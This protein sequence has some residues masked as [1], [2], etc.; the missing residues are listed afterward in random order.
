MDKKTIIGLVLIFAIFVGYM[1]WI[2]PSKEEQAAMRAHRDSIVAAF[3]DSVRQDSL[4]RAE[5]DSIRQ[6]LRDSILAVNPDAVIDFDA[7]SSQ[8]L[9]V[10]DMRNQLGMFGGNLADRVDTITVRNGVFEVDLTNLGAAVNKVTLDDYTTYDS[11]PLVLI[12]PSADNMNLVFSTNDNRV[13]N[14][15]DLYFTPYI[16]G[17]PAVGSREIGV[18]EDSVVVSYRAY[19]QQENDTAAGTQGEAYVEFQYTFHPRS[20]EV[21]YRIN[22][23]GLSRVI[24]SDNY[25]DFTWRNQ[26]N[27]QE[28]V[29]RSS[30]GSRN[31]NKDAEKFNSN[32]YF[33][34]T[35]DKVDNLRL[36]GDG[37]KQVKTPVEW[38]A[39]KQQFFCAILMG[40][41]PFLN[42]D[43]ATKTDKQDTSRNYLCDMSGTIALDYDSEQ[44]CSIGMQFYYGPSKYR[45]LREMHKG[46]ERMLPLGWGFF[47]IQ[48]TSRLLIVCF[49]FFAGF[50][51]NYGL[52]IILLTVLLRTALFPLT[53]KSYQSSAVMRI[54]QP[55]MQALNKKY[56]NQD[57]ALARQ[58]EMSKLQKR[59]G[60]S[61]MAGCLPALVQ[62]PILY[63]MFRFFPASIE[64]R[65]KPFLWCD[66]LSTYDSI[67]DF[68]F[69]IPLYGDH[70]SLFCLLMFGMQFF[71]TWYTMRG[72]NT[73]ASMPGMKFMMY[74][75]PFMM[76]FLFNSQSAALNL[77][78]FCSLSITMLQ[79]ILIRKFT[80]E[81]RVRARMAAYDLKQKNSKEPAKKSRLQQ[82]LEEMQRMSEQMQKER[83][84]QNRR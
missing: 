71:Y 10:A 44:D 15:K 34:P 42:A 14:T 37:S 70:M 35:K 65:Q 29:D 11:M 78:Y 4:M 79:M 20:Y 47:L 48:W 41:A 76:L 67:L 59:A 45:E 74:F 40:D 57:Q 2:S 55:E 77:Y 53:F 25:L 13:I 17:Q 31:R 75:M 36:G 1:W 69:N 8:P 46:F 49:R 12:S 81:K 39:F 6:H 24:R 26:M 56:P 63:A 21:G 82:R 68:G 50:M 7:A 61:P 38:V 84:Q 83:Q 19:A 22:F 60:I 51:S 5:Q 28:K 33:K 54:L 16:D 58:Q 9:S 30:L 23:R 27:R 43:L 3:Y 64:L 62:M 66:D 80:S 73:T 72:Q 32:V 18:E 52:I